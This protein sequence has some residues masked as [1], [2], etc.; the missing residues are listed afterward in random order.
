MTPEACVILLAVTRDAQK[1]YHRVRGPIALRD[2][3]EVE[4]RLD[5]ALDT[6]PSDLGPYASLV[7]SAR[8][9]RERQRAY[10]SNRLQGH[11]RAALQSEAEVDRE[12]RELADDSPPAPPPQAALPGLGPI[13]EPAP[14]RRSA[15]RRRAF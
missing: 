1:L 10:W 8:L 12:L 2:A 3:L 6:L 15:A 14:A 11:L 7:G 5:A 9:M 13:G 4:R